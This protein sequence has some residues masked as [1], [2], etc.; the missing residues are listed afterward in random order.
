[1]IQPP[2][3]H[4]SAAAASC[5]QYGH[6]YVLITVLTVHGSA[7]RPAGSKMLVT[8]NEQVDTIGGGHLEYA[9]IAQ[10][11]Q[12]LQANIAVQRIEKYPLGPSLGQCCGGRVSL[13]YECFA[14]AAATV[15]VF[16]AGHVGRALVGIL[17]QLPVQV[18]WLD[19]RVD[20]FPDVIPSNVQGIVAE[21]PENEVATLPA[22]TFVVVMSHQ[23]PL[24][25]AVVKAVLDRGDAAYLGVIGSLTKAR[26]FRMRL[27]H[28]G[29][30]QEH[31][32]F[33][34]CPIGNS[35]VP[36]KRPMEVAVSVAAEL[37]AHYHHCRARLIPPAA[38]HLAEPSNEH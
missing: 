31:I 4:W 20:E 2:P 14:S 19:S 24:D 5:Q 38:P 33:I 28:Q 30:C 8:S 9:A 27:A 32:D 22:A 1:M 15:A 29:Y 26:R 36:G 17:A 11:R 23:H 25:Y 10:A 16:G 34:Q 6:A 37:I 3:Q 13:L 7:P 18:R 35:S 12:L 21:Q